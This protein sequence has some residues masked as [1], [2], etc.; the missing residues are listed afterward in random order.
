MNRNIVAVATE[1][2]RLL[3]AMRESDNALYI[4]SLEA[5]A[6]MLLEM[7][8]LEAVPYLDTIKKV[9]EIDVNVIDLNTVLMRASVLAVPTPLSI[10][11]PI[12]NMT[13][14]NAGDVRS[15]WCGNCKSYTRSVT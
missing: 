12:C 4:N 1:Y 5:A 11:C 8:P 3:I 6:R 2:A 13:S 9:M 10:T 14:W 15:G 7:T